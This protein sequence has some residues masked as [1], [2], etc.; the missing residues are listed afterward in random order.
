MRARRARHRR[1]L[2]VTALGAALSCAALASAA[3]L[4]RVFVGC[5]IYRDT[6]SGRKS[7]CWL[8]TDEALGIRYDISQSRT[9]PQLGH[10]VLVEGRLDSSGPPPAPESTPCGA[11]PLAPLVV[12]VL[13]ATCPSFLIPPEGYPGRR[14]HLDPKVVM[15]RADVPEPL[16]PPPY[17]PRSWHIEFTFQS[18]FLQYQYSEVI[19]DQIGR[20]IRASHPRRIDV[21]G[22]A[23]SAPRVVS[24]TTLA[25]SPALALAR[26]QMVALALRRLGAS[27]AALHVVGRKNPP[28]LSE[29]LTEPSRRRVEVSVSY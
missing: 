3:D 24:G 12:S 26:A 8:A 16:P 1:W 20:Y 18:D 28:A 11:V 25:E 7:G 2:A 22:Y 15:S 10:Q 14:Y 29:E 19:L 23:V 9:K 27:E 4:Q 6:N 21:V 5:P 13:E 17:G